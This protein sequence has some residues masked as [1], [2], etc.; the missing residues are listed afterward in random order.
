MIGSDGVS[1]NAHGRACGY[2]AVYKSPTHEEDDWYCEKDVGHED[3]CGVEGEDIFWPN[4]YAQLAS[5]EAALL[6][7]F[8]IGGSS[9]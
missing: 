7:A 9:A 5:H 4:P 1:F 8:G 6:K 2:C 3:D